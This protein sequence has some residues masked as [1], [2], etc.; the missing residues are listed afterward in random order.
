MKMRNVRFLPFLFLAFVLLAIPA[1]SSAQVAVGLSVRVGPPPIPV[2]EQPLCPGEGYMW[3]PGYWSYASDDYFWVPGTWV[4]PPRVGLLW[5]PG[6]WGWEGG[7]YRW[8]GGYWG[9]H[10]GFYG[11]INYG[12]GY[13]GVGFF[14]G[15]WRGGA[16]FYNRAFARVNVTNI[17]NTYN[18]TVV[19]NNSSHTSFNGGSGGVNAQPNASERNAEHENHV[20]ATT[21][22]TNHEH[23]ASTNRS[24][25]N[26]VNHGNPSVTGTSRP[27]QFS[28]KGGSSNHSGASD[29]PLN[30]NRGG[31]AN[32]TANGTG[33]G[34]SNASGTRSG[35]NG[36]TRG[37][38]NS[39]TRGGANGGNRS[40][41]NGGTRSGNN[42]GTRGGA[43]GG[44]R[45]GSTGG[46]RGG[47]SG[48]TRGSGVPRGGG[49]PRGGAGGGTG[50]RGGR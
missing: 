23:S 50:K 44:N 3:T 28:G 49:A 10:V 43:N 24:Q 33:K 41:T 34:T 27:G 20:G 48:G 39:G 21:S 1:A 15:Y 17:H 16:F 2:Y 19:N 9:P 40:G 37:G 32:G 11:G 35:T 4:R 26:G 5:T 42:S 13:G 22:Q 7:F 46:N 12:F 45:G 47:A 31:T 38:N 36:G 30:P 8:R 25:F 14:G 18:K 29:H 6:W